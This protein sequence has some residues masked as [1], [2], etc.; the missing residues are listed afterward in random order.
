MKILLSAVAVLTFLVLPT[1]SYAVTTDESYEQAGEQLMDQMMGTAH[2]QADQNIKEMMGEDFLRQMHISMGKMAER[3]V[4]GNSSLGM[5][6]MM[7]M[8][9][10][11]GGFNMMG[12]NFGMMGGSFWPVGWFW[13]ILWS[14]TWILVIVALAALIRWLWKKGEK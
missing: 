9:M 4:S 11:G 3:N 12:G 1:T 13:M 6:P 14:V 5:M 2:E 7:G 8:M 10:G